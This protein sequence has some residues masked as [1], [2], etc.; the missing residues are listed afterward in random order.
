MESNHSHPSTPISLASDELK[1][2]AAELRA[3]GPLAGEVRSR[4]LAVRAALFQRGIFDPVL[5]RFDT[6]TV[7]RAS[8][9]E[10]ADQLDSLAAS[11]TT[12]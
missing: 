9:R 7:P 2:L 1:A 12:L 4:F 6:I 11:L 8:M 3:S 5:V 10:I